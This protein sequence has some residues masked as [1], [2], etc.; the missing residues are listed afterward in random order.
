MVHL[1]WLWTN[2]LCLVAMA[3][4][5]LLALQSHS[6]HQSL[7]VEQAGSEQYAFYLPLE[8]T[9]RVFTKEL[10]DP[11]S[12]EYQTM[13]KEVSDLLNNVYNCSS[14]SPTYQYYGGVYAMTFSS[15]S[16]I[17]N[18]TVIFHRQINSALVYLFFHMAEIQ[19]QILQINL[20]YT[21][22]K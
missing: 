18:S 3:G 7:S 9:N 6:L 11:A 21:T 19:T 2:A 12:E 20:T 1:R 16:V 8:I 13:Y 17:A 5:G 15:G 14:C 22:R 4:S 10:F